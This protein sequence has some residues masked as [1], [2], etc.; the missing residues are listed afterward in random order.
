MAYLAEGI[1]NVVE[2]DQDLALCDFGDVVHRLAG[3]V[4]DAGI[5]IGKAGENGGHN[6]L[7]VLGKLLL[8]TKRAQG[9]V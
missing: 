2:I 4:A 6:D 3:V 9:R 1:K 8:G 5:L 7:E